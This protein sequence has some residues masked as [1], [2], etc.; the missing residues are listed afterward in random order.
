MPPVASPETAAV[1]QYV[2]QSDEVDSLMQS[3]SRMLV[4]IEQQASDVNEYARRLDTAYKELESTSAQL[5]EFSFKDEVTHLYNRRFFAIRL[6]E[7]IARY[8]RFNHPV[9]LVLLDLDGFKSINDQFGHGAGDETLRAVAEHQRDAA[10]NNAD[11]EKQQV[12]K[13]SEATKQQ[14]INEAL[15]FLLRLHLRRRSS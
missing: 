13:A 14:R 6:E 3:F 11:G 2:Q 9:S 4:T 12:I 10:I 8:R 15:G 5:K 7:E 1:Q